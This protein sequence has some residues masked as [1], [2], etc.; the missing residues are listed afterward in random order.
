MVLW[1]FG[2]VPVQHGLGE[3]QELL[4]EGSASDAVPRSQA[5][6]AFDHAVEQQAHMLHH[7]WH[8]WMIHGDVFVDPLL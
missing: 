1:A 5:V 8:E 2:W 4:S 3:S 6:F 7:P